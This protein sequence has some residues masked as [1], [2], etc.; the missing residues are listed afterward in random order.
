MSVIR[1]DTFVAEGV[2]F[3]RVAF[4]VVIHALHAQTSLVA[5]ISRDAVA[6]AAVR[7]VTASR[8]DDKRAQAANKIGCKL[9]A[10]M[11]ELLRRE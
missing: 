7:L 6:V 9:D 10:E 11:W 3:G 1:S 5:E 2:L 8:T 4:L